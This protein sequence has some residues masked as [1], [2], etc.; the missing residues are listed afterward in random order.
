LSDVKKNT[1]IVLLAHG[2]RD[3]SW[4]E[5]FENILDR[6]RRGAEGP[7][8]LAFLDHMEPSVLSACEH[9]A[10][11]GVSKIALVPLF[12]GVGGHVKGDVPQLVTEASA[13]TG[14]AIEITPAIGE[15]ESLVQSIADVS[16]HLVTELTE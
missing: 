4:R 3:P 13:K 9:L 11:L 15:T 1:G 6:V 7:V 16:L 14:V 12:L 2:A 10:A 5:P 8:S